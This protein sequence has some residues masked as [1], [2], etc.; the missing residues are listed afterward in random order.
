MSTTCSTYPY[1][2]DII[3]EAFNLLT[4]ERS[5]K[6]G[7][8]I[9]ACLNSLADK[10]TKVLQDHTNVLYFALPLWDYS[11]NTWL[12]PPANEPVGRFY[13]K[14]NEWKEWSKT[15]ECYNLRCYLKL[16]SHLSNFSF[17]ELFTKHV[18][19][20]KPSYKIKFDEKNKTSYT[21]NVF[22][23]L[24]TCVL[25]FNKNCDD[26]EFNKECIKF[27][28]GDED[29]FKR[30]KDFLSI[31]PK[32]FPTIK[33]IYFIPS[34][35][36]VADG[37]TNH[38]SSGGLILVCKKENSLSIDEQ[39]LLSILVNICYRECGG[40]NIN[41][42]QRQEAKK[43]A[44][45][46][47]MSRNLSHNL[48]S[49]VMFYIK[50]KLE[51][52]NKIFTSGSLKDL[53]FDDI[54]LNNLIEL[55]K[56]EDLSEAIK[57]IKNRIQESLGKIEK[58]KKLPEMPFLIGLSRFL[59]Y[60]QE[61]QDFIATVATN[62]IPYKAIINF[63][64]SIYDELKPEKHFLRH[65]GDITNQKSANLLLDY[66]AKS[67]G[68][69][70]SD[71]IELWFGDKFDGGGF[72]EKESVPSELRDFNVALPGGNLGRQA[73]FSI[74]ENIIRNTAKHEGSKEKCGNLAFQFDIIDANKIN[75]ID[76]YSKR[77]FE[78]GKNECLKS[79]EEI[80]CFKKYQNDLYY[81]GI[82]VKLNSKD[83]EK[84]NNTIE[85]IRKGLTKKYL[86][87]FGQMN[88]EC[89]GLKEMRI[90]A[91]WIRGYVLD[92]EIPIEEPPAL[93]IRNNGGYLQYIIG[94]PKPK[95]VAIINSFESNLDTDSAKYFELINGCNKIFPKISVKDIKAI[96]DIADHEIVI[97]NEECNDEH[98]RV[99]Q[100]NVGARI[101]KASKE[102]IEE[103][104]EEMAKGKYA[105]IYNKL[106]KNIFNFDFNKAPKISILD[107]VSVKK[108]L[109]DLIQQS[110]TSETQNEYFEDCIVYSRHYKGQTE[111][112]IK[113]TLSKA[114]FIEAISGGNSTYRLV[115]QCKRDHEWYAKH[116]TAGL[117]K[118]A[119]FD[120]RIFEL[121]MPKG[122][123][124]IDE[125]RDTINEYLKTKKQNISNEEDKK[126]FFRSFCKE[127]IV[128]KY[129]IKNDLATNNIYPDLLNNSNVNCDSILHT[130]SKYFYFKDY[131]KTWQYR[132]KGIWA[133]NVEI[134][135]PNQVVIIGYT[136]PVNNKIGKFMNSYK[137][138]PLAVIKKCN[139]K[140]II[141]N[142]KLPK[143]YRFDFITI[144]QGILDK[145]YTTLE[146]NDKKGKEEV[147]TK[148]YK[149]FM[150]K[151]N[152]LKTSFLPRLTIH[153]GRSKPNSDDMPQKQPFIQ[154]S[155][156]EHAVR[157]CKY[158]LTELLYSAHYE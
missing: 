137:E 97:V 46:A 94:L 138:K 70:S 66:I 77:K 112:K 158:S 21:E 144:H 93:S 113:S 7:K 76:G 119:I 123:F 87:D 10:I 18:S 43:S 120:E 125:I 107:G 148:L 85:K 71:K 133:F 12:M 89:K 34:L 75:S 31:H 49:H 128:T 126:R 9:S 141:E 157:D 63:K 136:A 14:K 91:A 24:T 83:K 118:I 37:N 51:S 151:G 79:E 33:E 65:K 109:N 38:T 36:F 90:S 58:T 52:V 153:S 100:A 142:K 35:L 139:D 143:N 15:G 72:G 81:L 47:I 61:R 114:S 42:A 20:L 102:E 27:A 147:T 106:L 2:F 45:A 86:D 13:I 98:F 105:L 108:D 117:T 122:N 156:L 95:K 17:S 80:V 57:I 59:N 3:N 48:G 111:S 55:N 145:I 116:I 104:K 82:T 30:F 103:F 134:S 99:L 146:I 78:N 50:Q 150:R 121:I 149:A 53:F 127:V 11:T 67:E 25:S 115:N 140:I 154:F 41:T 155:S 28:E 4:P 110:G 88:E 29:Y 60:L 22:H 124:E 32:I 84:I 40:M 131:S 19:N 26:D 130:L 73:L 44:K 56:E 129:N 16:S 74:M 54:Q 62:Y 135:K 96:N 64:D 101:F 8:N 39:K 23:D 92:D 68:F 152:N 1:K 69:D 5:S 6:N 132:E